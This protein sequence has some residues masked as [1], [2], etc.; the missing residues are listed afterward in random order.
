MYFMYYLRALEDYTNAQW[1]SVAPLA[2][3]TVSTMA[4]TGVS[5]PVVVDG[6][7]FLDALFV[8]AR[9]DR[10]IR[11]HPLQVEGRRR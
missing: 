5:R 1:H 8:L 4:Q 7:N 9:Q 2:I 6:E 10:G 11:Q 3:Y